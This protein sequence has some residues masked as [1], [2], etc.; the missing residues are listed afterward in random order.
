MIRSRKGNGRQV[1]DGRSWVGGP[2]QGKKETS[3]RVAENSA[4][5]PFCIPDIPRKP[6]NAQRGLDQGS[7]PILAPI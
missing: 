5:S 4:D 1:G 6:P 3:N 7:G 2:T